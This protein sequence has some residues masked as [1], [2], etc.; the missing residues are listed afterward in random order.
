MNSP[1]RMSPDE[2]RAS[3]SLASVFAL[4]LFGMF[5]ILPV[6]ALYTEGRPGWSLTLAGIALGIYGLV[7]GTLQIPFGWASDR[8]GRKPLIYAGL[9]A[10]AA[11]SFVCAAADSPG[12]MI[13]G[14]ALQG[15]GAVSGVVIA[16]AADL[17]RESQR[18]KSMG[19]IGSTIGAAFAGSFVAAP[20]LNHT[21][22][23][24]GI[25][26]LTGLLA[27]AAVAVVRFVVPDA[28]PVLRG[29]SAASLAAVVCD[30]ELLRLNVGIFVLHAVLMATF[31]VLPVSLVR[32]GLPASEHWSVYLGT[33]IAG[34][35][36]M[37]P[38]MLGRAAAHERRV[39]LAA[40]G[41]VTASI[42]LLA[43]RLESVTAIVAGLVIFFAG[44]NVL[45]AKLPAL[46][47]R[48]AP[49]G[50]RG[51]ATGV[52][53]SVQFLGTF[54]G[55]AAGGAL[56]QHASFVAVLAACL[57]AMVAWLAVAWGMQDLLPRAPA[58]LEIDK[59]GII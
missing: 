22:G 27:L 8:L 53:S 29:A 26:A 6:F 47:S 57:A 40:I 33:V 21:I 31:V 2:L 13:A 10:M 7:Q 14:R 18:T 19:I 51:A 48:A 30:P 58:P 41:T 54:A 36:L 4:R 50:A 28:P 15:A 59:N 11:G 25:F 55:A 44:F 1:A 42:A 12:M 20:F 43:A 35:L 38:A 45:E 34:F 56:A 46:V 24:P 9:A 23:V 32:A 17:T 49:R 5:V 37:L 39:F 52:Y 16:L 3:L